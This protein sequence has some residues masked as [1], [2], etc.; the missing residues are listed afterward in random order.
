MSN[1]E[2]FFSGINFRIFLGFPLQPS[3]DAY[4]QQLFT[5]FDSSICRQIHRYSSGLGHLG[6]NNTI[7]FKPRPQADVDLILKWGTDIDQS[8]RSINVVC[9]CTFPMCSECTLISLGFPKLVCACPLLMYV[10]K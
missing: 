8:L 6:Q 2:E 10:L 7:N 3:S 4:H 5:H 1:G 9:F